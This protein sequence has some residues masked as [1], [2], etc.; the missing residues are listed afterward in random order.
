M[1][2]YKNLLKE[3]VEVLREKGK[4]FLDGSIS[5]NEF[6]G[7]SG[8][9]GSYAQ[10]ET[11]KFMIRL[12]TPSGIIS[13]EH[14]DLILDYAGENG[15]DKIHLTTRQAIQLHELTIDQV[16]DIM[17][18]GID[19]D[20]F[21]RGG[22]GNFP[23][24]VALSPMAGVDPEEI[25]DV[26]P[27][28]L[29]VGDYFFRNATTYKLPR[30]LKVAFSSSMAD[31]AGA[32]VNDMGFIPVLED[33]KPMFRMWLAGGM[34]SN[35][36]AGILYDELVK[37]EEVLYY[38]EAM[39]QL[40]KAEGDYENKAKARIRYIPRRMGVEAFI[41]CYKDHLK[42]VRENH[43]FEGFAPVVSRPVSVEE[44]GN[45]LILPQKQEGRYTVILHPLCGQL[46]LED[47]RKIQKLIADMPEAE[48][49]LSMDED[50]YVRQLTMEQA[51]HVLDVMKDSMKTES[52]AMSV[53]C[54]G[55]P[56]CQTGVNQSQTLC[57]N[58]DDAVK[59]S[60]INPLYL[61]RVYISG[62]PNCCSRHAAAALGFAGRRIKVDDQMVEAFDCYIGG[63][64]GADRV[65]LVEKSGT[66]PAAQIPQMIVEL[67][68][69]LAAAGK[70]YAIAVGDGSAGA[71][72]GKY[73]VA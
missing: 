18:D 51:E 7:F 29:L 55:T 69:M 35:P 14:F 68:K 70:D 24:N 11:G 9:M 5:R 32:A 16:C 17:K 8:G 61:P 23:R 2:E 10:K 50:L 20:L 36:A 25:F 57:K 1:Q 21:T 4:A 63:Q 40:F 34:G 37:P 59:A 44:S 72:I 19:H 45:P 13:R 67:G 15:L 73:F 58:I 66:I 47:G 26:T 56:T 53:A 3:E 33:G 52:V 27:Y 65:K 31:T 54:V 71:L 39:V 12:R 38:I 22:G 62:C 60:G 48:L 64:T 30:K 42:A 28:A 46:M 41:Q 49:R 43:T 6:K